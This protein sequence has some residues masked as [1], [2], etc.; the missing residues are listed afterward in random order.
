MPATFHGSDL[1]KIVKAYGIAK[2]DLVS[3]SA[4]VN[5]LGLPDS[6]LSHIKNHAE[7]VG[8]YPDRD[9]TVLK[10]AI[11]DYTGADVDSIIVGS[12]ATELISTSIEA[13]S[14]KNVLVVGPTYSEYARKLKEKNAHIDIFH[15]EESEDFVFNTEGFCKAVK[16]HDLIMI[17]NPNNPTATSLE[18]DV[19]SMICRV[20]AREGAF[21]FMDETYVEFTGDMEKY[22]GIKATAKHKNIAI[23]RGTSKF[24]ACPGLRLGYM[25]CTDRDHIKTMRKFM[26][27]WSVNSLAATA[28][29]MFYDRDFME[30]TVS[31]IRKE[32]DKLR[33]AL[34]S[35]PFYVYDSKVNFLLL[36]I[37]KEGVTSGEIFDYCVKRGMM[38]RDC[39]S[40]ETLGDRHIRICVGQSE[41]NDKL[42]STLNNFFG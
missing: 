4:N 32:M 10:R 30:R 20:A 9:Y 41:Y 31:Y 6:L 39:S 19:I 34:G 26:D 5:P 22:S 17:C 16:G 42:I 36:R 18:A 33:A 7:V 3:F 8:A 12:G 21:V 28:T 14:P 29:G 40:F 13:L 2:E 1:E 27:P 35:L 38:I 24:F 37:E 25:I 11:S 15:L 23:I